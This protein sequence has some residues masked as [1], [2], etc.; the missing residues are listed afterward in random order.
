MNKMTGNF[1]PLRQKMRNGLVRIEVSA[2]SMRVGKTTAVEVIAE[3]LGKQGKKVIKSYEDWQNN[4][5]LKG[6][7]SDPAK[8]FFDSQK[9]FIRRKWEQVRDGGEGDIFIQD[10]APET[11]FCYA[12]TNVKLGRM[13]QAHFDEYVEYYQN[14]DWSLAPA[15][16]L[17]VYL[18]TG[19]DELIQRAMDSR[20]E[21]EI[22]EPE[23]FLMMKKV[24]REW[25]EMAKDRMNILVV[26]TDKLDFAHDEGAKVA[27]VERVMQRLQ[28]DE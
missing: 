12:A 26:D 7:Y 10:V 3:G 8:N 19:D 2:D 5:Y 13:S 20:R 18:A 17:M 14:L 23:Y 21:F 28:D 9:W 27:L 24:N 25:L 4:P 15:P 16:N 6:S 1:P 11:D 22:V